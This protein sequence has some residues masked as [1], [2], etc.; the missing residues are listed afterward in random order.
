MLTV[1]DFKGRLYSVIEVNS[2]ST[3][4]RC[5]K[6]GDHVRIRSFDWHAIGF[7]KN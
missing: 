2:Q 1:K 7:I 3:L 6:T 5:T 4:L